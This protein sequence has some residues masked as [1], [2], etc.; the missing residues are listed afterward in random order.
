MERLTHSSPMRAAI[1]MCR[2]AEALHV[3]E[4]S[5]GI[6]AAGYKL[7]QHTISCPQCF[8]LRQRLELFDQEDGLNRFRGLEAEKHLD[9]W[10]KGFLSSQALGPPPAPWVRAPEL[11]TVPLP[12]RP[13]RSMVSHIQWSLAAAAMLVIALGGIYIWR[14]LVALT[15]AP[16]IAR[17]TPGE[18]L[19]P[20][21]EPLPVP[22][23][24][25]GEDSKPKRVEPK[26]PKDTS[27]ARDA[28]AGKVAPP[29]SSLDSR[30]P[31]GQSILAGAQT[32]P[33]AD[34]HTPAVAGNSP[35]PGLSRRQHPL[36]PP[37]QVS[38]SRAIQPPA[39]IRGNAKDLKPKVPTVTPSL[40]RIEAGTRI[41]IVLEST[42][43]QGDGRLLF[44]GHLLLPVSASNSIVLD[45][46][47]RVTGV[48]CDRQAPVSVQ[49]S[50]LVLHGQRYKVTE[51]PGAS[52]IPS[53][54]TGRAV[55]FENGKAVEMWL[56][57]ATTF[58]P[59]ETTDAAPAN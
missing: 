43:A 59:V 13:K 45:K 18:H 28:S 2:E 1:G 3:Q 5:E 4:K 29:T 32:A 31:P 33:P 25:P 58:E 22:G 38:L 19:S 47:T 54:G 21:P 14:S 15:P 26:V 53:T 16:S 24:A 6:D 52:A 11:R 35:L 37:A 49:I 17:A 10:L 7:S 48:C 30:V 40:I 41:W 57:S 8:A 50:E 27:P 34:D 55:Q 20:S 9:S 56:D 12:F 51:N 46:A 23:S 44:E 39:P 36:L 42:T